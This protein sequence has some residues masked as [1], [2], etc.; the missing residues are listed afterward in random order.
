MLISR[1]FNPPR[2]TRFLYILSLLLLFSFS[3]IPKVKSQIIADGEI[4]EVESVGKKRSLS[5]PNNDQIASITFTLTGGDGGYA[6]VY[7]TNG[8]TNPSFKSEGGEGAK[9]SI[10]FTVGTGPRD[11]PPG[12]VFRVVGG[13]KGENG[14]FK[15]PN[16]FGTSYGGGGGGSALLVSTPP[17]WIQTWRGETLLAV[18]GGGGGAYQGMSSYQA[19]GGKKGQGGRSD[20][21]GLGNHNVGYGGI[22]HITSGGGGGGHLAPSLGSSCPAGNGFAGGGGMGNY[23]I[24]QGGQ[25]DGC[26][27][28]WING[29]SGYGGGGAGGGVGGGGGGYSGGGAGQYDRIAG[30]GGSYF[31]VSYISSLS[32]KDGG[33]TS[34][35]KNGKITYQVEL[36]IPPEAICQDATIYLDDS[37]NAILSVNDIDNGSTGDKLIKEL[38]QTDFTCMDAGTIH[39]IILKVTDNR[40]SSASCSANVSIKDTISPVAICKDITVYLDHEG[41]AIIDADTIDNGSSDNCSIIKSID[42]SEFDCGDIGNPVKVTLTVEDP[43]GNKNQCIAT[44]TVLDT[45][46]PIAKCKDIVVFLDDDGKATIVPDNIDNGSSDNCSIIKSI[47]ISEFDCEDVG[48]PVAVTLTVEDP[49]GNKSSCKAEVTVLDT[50]PPIAKCKNITIFLDNQGAAT[51]DPYEIEDSSSDN[52]FIIKSINI[53]EFDCDDIDNP[54]RVKLTVEDPGGNTAQCETI[55]TVLDTIAPVA[56]CKDIIVY[57]DDHGKA[58]IVPDDIDNGSYDNCSIV[59]KSI[60]IFEFDCDDIGKSIPVTLSVEDSSG[61]KGQCKAT[62]TVLDTISP[63]VRTR[64]A[65]VYLDAIGKASIDYSSI[66]DNSDD[67]C[68]IVTWWLEGK[69]QYECADTGYHEVNLFV[70]DQSGN[71]SQKSSNVMVLDTI[72]PIAKC[73]DITV[74]LDKYGKIILDADDIDNGSYDNCAVV[75]K[76]LNR[77]EF[78]CSD[79]SNPVKVTLT[80]KDPSGNEDH[81]IAYVTVKDNLSPVVRAKN[82]TLVLDRYGKTSVTSAMVDDGSWDNCSIVSM[83][84]EGNTVFDCGDEGVHEVVLKA[85]DLN[86]NVGSSNAFV[87]VNSYK[88]DFRNKHGVAKGDTIHRVDCQVP[89][90]ISSNDLLNSAEIRRHGTIRAYKSREKLPKDA[91][92]SMYDLWRYEYTFEDY[93]GRKFSFSFYLALYDLHPPIFQNFP[94]DTSI[95][96]MDE[97]P[98]VDKRVRII[99]VCQY[100][101]WDTVYTTPVVDLTTGDTLGLTRRWMAEDPSGHR[102]FR[103]QMIWI[104]SGKRNLYGQISG[105]LVEEEHLLT[106]RHDGEAGT[107]GIPVSLYRIDEEANTRTWIDSWATGDWM[108]AQGTFH[109]VPHQPG[110]YQVKL[111]SSLCLVD[112]FKF[113]K[114]LWS[115]TLEVIAGEKVDLGWII[116]RKCAEAD[117]R[118]QEYETETESISDPGSTLTTSFFR[119]ELWSVYPN[120]S[121]GYLHINIDVDDEMHYRIYDALGRPIKHGLFGRGHTID[122]RG[123]NAGVYHLQ[124]RGHNVSTSMKR[125]ILVK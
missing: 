46:S 53:S 11:V 57:L 78:D 32:S 94:P 35:P 28:S 99:D 113:D 106:V 61:N 31:N 45:I 16:G 18:A 36:I 25:S 115:D 15:A 37:G 101:V 92:W 1:Q 86:G 80:V 56:E 2:R 72:S 69:T 124:L 70:R 50:I 17:G 105:R 9:I 55:V 97:V 59:S 118:D 49:S 75:S 64:N 121:E 93:C 22:S 109:F 34:T 120:P 108:G 95:V 89:W 38:S 30:G 52:C 85:R 122:L 123:L 12:A 67:N 100:V 19:S 102:S 90:G 107:N 96:S 76:S 104:G 74:Y 66:N 82:I 71:T 62:V 7:E 8:N 88:P 110:F 84:L 21:S 77:Y 51:I 39:E 41:K 10:T 26:P 119:N 112:T 68:N 125:I 116:M 117:T 79:I 43:S 63:T 83:W 27:G 58:T 114:N 40:K 103:D 4:H 3:S 65:T 73:K 81:C 14:D 6:R 87:S 48:K 54:A 20:I 47:D 91:S 33:S 98:K 44:V 24:G 5:L 29:G 13:E 111:D 23:N 42:I 60:D